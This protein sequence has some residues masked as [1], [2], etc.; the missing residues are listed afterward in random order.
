VVAIQDALATLDGVKSVRYISRES[1]R[2]KLHEI[3]GVDLLEELDENPL[4]RSIILSFE[5]N[6]LNS[7]NLAGL[8]S[9]LY[10]LKG[11]EE[12]SF[13]GN[14]LEKAESTKR[15]IREFLILLGIVIAVAVML[16]SVHSI[17]LSTRT[18]VEEL[19][20]LKLLGFS[21]AFLS[22]P[23]IMEGLF[24]TLIAAIAGWLG[25]HYGQDFVSFK[26]LEI[27]IPASIDMAYFCLAA[28][29]AGT[30]GG[31]IGISRRI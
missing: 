21:P 26:N 8:S 16:N 23:F 18:K 1:A 5:P 28:A 15:M 30:L 7:Q 10:R 24:Y 22:V 27:V 20:Q 13:P 17:I 3:M 6:Y 9:D 29:I 12:I 14:W 25:I 11:V 19:S 31:Y 4:P 2:Q